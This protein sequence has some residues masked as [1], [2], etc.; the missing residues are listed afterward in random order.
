ME[1]Q[2]SVYSFYDTN[3]QITI[4]GWY[5]FADCLGYYST[6]EYLIGIENYLMSL[7]AVIV[8]VEIYKTL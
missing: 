7:H 5:N 4:A 2:A 6:F 3:K 1:I 8:N